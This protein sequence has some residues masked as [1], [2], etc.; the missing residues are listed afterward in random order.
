[1]MT[2]LSCLRKPVAAPWIEKYG[3]SCFVLVN[4]EN[5]LLQAFEKGV[6]RLPKI[7]LSTHRHLPMTARAALRAG[8]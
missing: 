1:M 8:S 6:D 2:I 5:L 3:V 4:Q 7:N